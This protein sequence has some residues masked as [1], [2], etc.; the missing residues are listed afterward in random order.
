M[1]M[2]E[3]ISAQCN[4]SKKDADSDDDEPNP[5]TVLLSKIDFV[6]ISQKMMRFCQCLCLPLNIDTYIINC[7]TSVQL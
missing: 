7:S 1:D 4:I 6:A 3:L 5:P 2:K